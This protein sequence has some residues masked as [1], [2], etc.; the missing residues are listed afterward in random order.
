MSNSGKTRVAGYHGLQAIILG[1]ALLAL[2][3]PAGAQPIQ[4]FPIDFGQ[5]VQGTLDVFDGLTSTGRRADAYIFNVAAP[6]QRYF[7]IAQSP[8][9]PLISGLYRIG[10]GQFFSFLPQNFV[11]GSASP[12]P[13]RVLVYSGVLSQPGRYAILVANRSLQ[14][15][16]GPSG[17]ARYTLSLD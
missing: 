6:G 12:G 17:L 4:S 8:D 5:Q 2:S 3:V 15:P 10:R 7:I 14:Q 13:D 1:L 16:T 9:I 11:N